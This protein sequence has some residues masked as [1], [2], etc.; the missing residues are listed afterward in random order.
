MVAPHGDPRFPYCIWQVLVY[1]SAPVVTREH[2]P[3]NHM[4]TCRIYKASISVNIVSFVAGPNLKHDSFGSISQFAHK[5]QHL[6]QLVAPRA[7]WNL[8]ASR[9][10][11]FQGRCITRRPLSTR[12]GLGQSYG[13]AM[14]YGL[15]YEAFRLL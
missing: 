11:Y 9:R 6:A 2:T 14:S 15:L 7:P 12:K 1:L 5:F 4:A 10:V 8:Q 3:G 13:S